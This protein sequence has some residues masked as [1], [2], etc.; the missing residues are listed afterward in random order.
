MKKKISAV[1]AAMLLISVATGCSKAEETGTT[2]ETTAGTTT[3]AVTT[4]QVSTEA[5]EGSSSDFLPIDANTFETWKDID[6]NKIIAYV[7]GNDSGKFDVTFGEFYSEYLYYLISNNIADDMS[8]EYK[9]SCEQYRDDVIT[10]ITFERIVFEVAE[11]LGC[12]ES[13]LTEEEVAQIKENAEATK[14]KII[15]NYTAYAASELGD[16]AT[17]AEITVRAAELLEADLNRAEIDSSIFETWEKSSFIQDKLGAY[18]IKDMEVTEEDIDAMFEEYVGY[19]KEL[20]AESKRSF[21]SDKTLSMMYVPEGTRFADQILVAFDSE[22][23]NAISQARMS[24]N[25]EEADRLRNEAYNDEMKEKVENI[26]ALI[27]SGEDFDTL[28]ATYNDDGADEPYSVIV[29]SELYVTEFTEAVF[30]IDE[31]GGV[32]EPALSDFGIHIIKYVGDDS[33]TDEELAAI[34]ADMRGYLEYTEGTRLQQEAYAE[35][36]ER[37]PYTIDYEL[38]KITE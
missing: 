36:I 8:E 14:Q 37:F 30:S 27:N 24:G 4:T 16:D 12:G 5:A 17:A 26:V 22:T 15:S 31:I 9:A 2:S 29:G 1:L 21:E 34:R 10:Y 28:Q 33:V 7:E 32:S 6:R 25:N 18:L 11:E 35:W 19:A 38:L 20:Y 3:E 23:M 13:S